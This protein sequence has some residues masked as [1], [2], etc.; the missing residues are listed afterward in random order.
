MPNEVSVDVYKSFTRYL[1]KYVARRTEYW[2]NEF[3]SLAMPEEIAQLLKTNQEAKLAFTEMI[4]ARCVEPSVTHR[5]W[6]NR[7]KYHTSG[8]QYACT[9]SEILADAA[10]NFNLF[11]EKESKNIIK[12]WVR[13]HT[14]AFFCL[15]IWRQAEKMVE[16]GIRRN[17]AFWDPNCI[18]QSN[19][20]SLTVTK[21]S[22]ENS[23]ELTFYADEPLSL[24]K[25]RGLS[26]KQRVSRFQ[27]AC[28]DKHIQYLNCC[29]GLCLS[30][31][32][33]EGWHTAQCV[34]LS[35]DWKLHK[36]M[37][38]PRQIIK[39]LLYQADGYY[40]LR[41]VDF[42]LQVIS[43]HASELFNL[44]RQRFKE[45]CKLNNISL[46]NKSEPNVEQ[47]DSTAEK[48]GFDKEY[49]QHYKYKCQL[50]T[51]H[52]G[53]CKSAVVIKFYTDVHFS[54]L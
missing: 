2:I 19:L 33:R 4:W 12:D 25:R 15:A 8:V 53:F 6:D 42:K 18:D 39:A 47:E 22:N 36:V 16:Y 38:G 41:L 46:V 43:L 17:L 14:F 3:K 40:I 32:N 5:R 9:F 45:Y 11:I 44:M 52:S 50:E 54:N 48:M 49:L 30:W 20:F 13:W 35:V 37:V 28:N 10:A 1:R 31:S 27:T 23:V 21:S 51:S 29:K 7:I 26:K 24:P 34:E